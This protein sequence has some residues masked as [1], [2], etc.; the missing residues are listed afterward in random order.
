MGILKYQKNVDAHK[1]YKTKFMKNL[2]L[3][4][5]ENIDFFLEEHENFLGCLFV[6]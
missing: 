3:I 4:L 1:H 2:L 5:F 6:Q